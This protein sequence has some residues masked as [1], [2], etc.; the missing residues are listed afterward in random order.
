MPVI[1]KWHTVALFLLSI[2][3]QKEK[4]IHLT[5]HREEKYSTADKFQKVY[6]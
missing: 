6:Q 2:L 3:E 4:M 5:Y 1:H